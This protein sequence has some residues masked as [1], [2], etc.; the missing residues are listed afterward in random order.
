[1]SSLSYIYIEEITGKPIFGEPRN[2]YSH[3]DIHYVLELFFVLW[4]WIHTGVSDFF[5]EIK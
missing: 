3:P 2:L 4:S 1:M 5:F